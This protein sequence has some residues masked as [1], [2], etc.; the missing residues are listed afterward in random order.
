MFINAYRAAALDGVL[1]TGVVI[2]LKLRIRGSLNLAART[3]GRISARDSVSYVRK[4][5]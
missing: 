2:R 5:K 3:I 4:T 1:I